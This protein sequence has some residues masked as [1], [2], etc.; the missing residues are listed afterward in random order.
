[1]PKP[2]AYASLLFLSFLLF[3]TGI[4]AQTSTVT[5]RITNSQ[6]DTPMAGVSVTIKGKPGGTQTD[7]NGTFILN[8]APNDVLVFTYLGFNTREMAVGTNNAI[9]LSLSQADRKMDEVVVIG[10]GTQSRRT[11]TGAVSTVDPKV[12][13]SVPRTNAATALQGTVSGLRVQQN[14]GAPGATPTIVFRG[15]TDFNGS[16]APLFIV[17][18]IIVPSLYGI[19]AEDIESIDLLKDA[20][21]TAIYGARASNG[22]VLVSTKKGRKGRTQVSYTFKHA[23]NFVRRN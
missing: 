4:H 17:D 13:E 11:L 20:A 14:T 6:D 8:A 16:G 7:N 23:E 12:L 5:G 18:G 2:I 21:S 3:A 10:Y 15:G 9:N 1:M 19:N 22:V